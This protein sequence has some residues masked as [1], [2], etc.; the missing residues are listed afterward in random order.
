MTPA[1]A[2]A[3]EAQAEAERRW[4]RI[5]WSVIALGAAIRLVY[6]LIGH[7]PSNYVFSDMRGYVDRAVALATGAELQR[8]DAFY[9]PGTHMLLAGP[10]KIFGTG[11][12]GLRAGAV[13][14]W[15]LSSLTPVFAWR[16]ARYLISPTAAAVTAVLAALYPLHI[17]YGGFFSSETPSLA[18][19]VGA[20]WLIYRARAHAGR[21]AVAAA[22]A[23]G[24]AGAAAIA[25]RPQFLLNL[26]VAA[27][28]LLWAWR[29]RWRPAL[30]MLAAGLVLLVPV[31]AYTSSAADRLTGVSENGG[32]NF[33]QS[34][35]DA[36]LVRAGTPRLGVFEFGSPVPFQ[37]NTGRDY[38]FPDQQIWDQGFFYGQGLDCI[39]DDGL[40]HLSLLAQNIVDAT[41]T[42]VPFPLADPPEPR[43]W[44][45][46]T[47][48][49][50]SIALPIL[51]IVALILLVRGDTTDR[52]GRKELLLQLACLLPVLL[53]YDAEPRFRVLYDVFGLALLASLGVEAAQRL[54]AKGVSPRS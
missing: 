14:W 45:Q 20:L 31:L 25:N 6:V 39:R 48:V 3:P 12:S 35:C 19:L 40:G 27:A 46:A 51:V 7:P 18:L 53:I 10:F 9:P 50:Y 49:A 17:L 54:M 41:A 23:A 34:H 11:D 2:S 8:Y 38:N 28:P 26:A 33:F 44:A 29:S 4:T 30:A 21:A 37:Q 16:M 52:R 5:A 32:L 47:N 1:A 36:H 24:L 22:G 13:L 42:T 15:A 43:R